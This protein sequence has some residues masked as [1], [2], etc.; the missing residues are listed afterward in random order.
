MKGFGFED[1]EEVIYW[2]G[3][4]GGG[5]EEEMAPLSILISSWK[6]IRFN[7]STDARTLLKEEINS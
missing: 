1:R 3:E 7:V 5:D 2:R 4:W 6:N